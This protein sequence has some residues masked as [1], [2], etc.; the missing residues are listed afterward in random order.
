M[1]SDKPGMPTGVPICSTCQPSAR[2]FCNVVAATSEQ[3]MC[4]FLGKPPSIHYTFSDN[5][6]HLGPQNHALHLGPQ[7]YALH[8]TACT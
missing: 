1:L 2:L 5:A 4:T 7:S 6:L 3:N 8:T